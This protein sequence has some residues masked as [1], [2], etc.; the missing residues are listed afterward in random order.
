MCIRD[1]PDRDIFP[2]DL[3]FLEDKSTLKPEAHALVTEIASLQK[4]RKPWSRILVA[5]Y[6]KSLE[7]SEYSEFLSNMRAKSVAQQM[8]RSGLEPRRILSKGVAV[9]GPVLIDPEDRQ[10][11]YNQAVEIIALD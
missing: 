11:R 8:I 9:D 4:N 7:G 1:S 3:F 6:N 5:V 2:A 10:D